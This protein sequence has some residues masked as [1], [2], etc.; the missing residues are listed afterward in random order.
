MDGLKR[1]GFKIFVELEEL[2]VQNIFSLLNTVIEP[3]GNVQELHDYRDVLIDWASNGYIVIGVDDKDRADEDLNA[4]QTVEFLGRLEEL[5]RFDEEGAHWTLRDGDVRTTELPA[6][7]LTDKG[8]Q[9][10]I[11]VLKAQ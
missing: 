3:T 5:F 1:L 7:I 10:A 8:L 6:V 9:K 4:G 2:H 11:E